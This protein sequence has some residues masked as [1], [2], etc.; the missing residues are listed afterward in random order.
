MQFNI[1]MRMCYRKAEDVNIV[2]C[3][4]CFLGFSDTETVKN[5]NARQFYV[6]H[7]ACHRCVLT[8]IL[9]KVV[10]IHPGPEVIKHFSCSTQLSTKF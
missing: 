9:E 4:G 1:S 2:E 8:L 6:V 10:V 7:P 5:R 3:A